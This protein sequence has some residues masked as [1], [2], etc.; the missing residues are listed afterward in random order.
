ML[1]A[2][3]IVAPVISAAMGAQLQAVPLGFSESSTKKM[4]TSEQDS[5][6]PTIKD[7]FG[8]CVLRWL[9]T[10]DSFVGLSNF[11]FL[12]SYMFSMR[13]FSNTVEVSTCGAWWV[14]GY[15][16]CDMSPNPAVRQSITSMFC[17]SIQ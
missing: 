1:R 16:E 5:C 11:D 17:A 6:A 13:F 12:S 14:F 4:G 15:N 3:C 10:H 7:L 9:R 2:L 8:A